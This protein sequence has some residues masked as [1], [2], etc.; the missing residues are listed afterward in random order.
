MPDRIL[1]ESDELIPGRLVQFVHCENSTTTDWYNFYVVAPGVRRGR[2]AR[3]DIKYH[4][5]WN[6]QRLTRNNNG[7]DALKERHPEVYAWMLALLT[8]G[9]IWAKQKA[10]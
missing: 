4:G 2:K 3:P 1:F 8:E 7:T 5:A 10:P 6:G 9:R